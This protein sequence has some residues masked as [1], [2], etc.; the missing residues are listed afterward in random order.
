MSFQGKSSARSSMDQQQMI[1]IH[2]NKPSK[3]ASV[4][5]DMLSLPSRVSTSISMMNAES[6]KPKIPFPIMLGICLALG[7]LMTYGGLT[8]YNSCDTTHHVATRDTTIHKA[9]TADV[10]TVALNDGACAKTEKIDAT[11]Q[12]RL[13]MA[14]ASYTAA[15]KKAVQQRREAMNL[16][17]GFFAIAACFGACV[18]CEFGHLCCSWGYKKCY[19]SK[20][21]DESEEKE[22]EMKSQSQVLNTEHQSWKEDLQAPAVEGVLG[23]SVEKKPTDDILPSSEKEFF[24]ADDIVNAPIKDLS[25]EAALEKVLI[26][27]EMEIE[28][29]MESELKVVQDAEKAAQERI[30]AEKKAEENQR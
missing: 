14:L 27:K 3:K 18:V 13:M 12:S 9:A 2:V 8:F 1:N 22:S 17:D 23:I 25:G 16:R 4:D 26:E 7:A 30:A 6:D 21:V 15:A 29:Q 5:A 28:K 24:P 10:T 19:G 20:K 11:T